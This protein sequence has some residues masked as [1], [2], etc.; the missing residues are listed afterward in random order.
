MKKFCGR[1]LIHWSILAAQ[2][3]GI[4]DI[5]ITTDCAEIMEYSISLGCN[6]LPLRPMSISDDKSPVELALRH[7][8]N[9]LHFIYSDSLERESLDV[10]LLMPTCPLRNLEDIRETILFYDKNKG[11]FSSVISVSP[12]IANHNPAWM[13]RYGNSG[14]IVNA[15]SEHIANWPGRRQELP[16]YYIRNDF[17]YI[18]DSKNLFKELVPSFY[19]S[20][21]AL[22][23]CAHGQY[24][25][26]IN[27]EEEFELAEFVFE[28]HFLHRY[29]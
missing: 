16:L 17:A 6:Y 5:Y 12:A 27:S 8:V 21:P 28:R 14:E 10:L 1:P 7:A 25:I 26:D 18:F 15:F 29:L 13:C 23:I 3:M 4:S 20:K 9:H 19:G 11:H 2:Q 22:H 24:D